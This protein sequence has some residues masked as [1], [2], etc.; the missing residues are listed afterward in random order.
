MPPRGRAP[1]PPRE[2][3]RTDS[4]GRGDARRRSAGG[5]RLR[6]RRARHS[7]RGS[8]G[9][10]SSSP[11]HQNVISEPEGFNRAE[12]W[13]LSG[14]IQQDQPLC[15]WRV[16][17]D[18]RC[19]PVLQPRFDV[20]QPRTLAARSSCP[21][22]QPDVRDDGVRGI[23]CHR[24]ECLSRERQVAVIRDDGWCADESDRGVE[25]EVRTQRLG[26]VCRIVGHGQHDRKR[27]E[28]DRGRLG[29]VSAPHIGKRERKHEQR[30]ENV[31]LRERNIPPSTL[32]S[33]DGSQA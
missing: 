9:C 24:R 5:S 18:P 27:N 25:L 3:Q 1:A 19:E 12:R 2:Q 14:R 17:S 31:R 11:S 23:G 8:A 15:I 29:A 4:I 32:R 26:G 6:R 7:R 16:D 30:G 13:R 28:Q 21:G 22:R 20:P 33:R 10:W